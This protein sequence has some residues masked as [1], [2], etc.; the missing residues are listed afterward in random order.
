VRIAV[1][2]KMLNENKPG[3]I[4]RFAF[5]TLSRITRLHPDNDFIFIVDRPF[6]DNT[7]FPGNITVVR[8]FPSRHPVLWHPWFEYAVPHILKRHRADVFLSPDGFIPLSSTVPS[9]A[10]IHDLNFCH[11]P[12]DMPRL[13]SSF[14]RHFFPKYAQKAKVI[15]T[16][17]EHSKNDIVTLYRQPRD[18]IAVVRCGVSDVFR[19]LPETVQRKVKDELTGGS[20]YFLYVGS[21]L[22]RKNLVRLIRAFE[23]FKTDA[24]SKIKLVLL[25]AKMFKTAEVFTAWRRMKHKNDV[26]FIGNVSEEKLA[27][28]YGAAYCLTFV[29]YFEGFGLPVLEAMSC[30]VPVIS[31]AATCMPEVCKGAALMVDP[32]SVDSIAAAMKKLSFDE[33]LRK[34]LVGKGREQ[35]SCFSWENTSEMLWKCVEKAVS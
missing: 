32:F 19:P 13:Y 10:V 18:K 28:I 21:L 29:S 3:G 33:A 27:S 14:Y 8:S 9:V 15:V 23:I 24:D 5:E 30:D 17:S 12:D 34:A 22:P 1:N 31:S 4:R 26:L 35:I 11:Y 20:P 2:A 16:V 7:I 25:G 6:S